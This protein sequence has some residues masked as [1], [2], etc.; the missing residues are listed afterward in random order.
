MLVCLC[1]SSPRASAQNADNPVFPDV[2]PLARDS[3]RSLPGLIAA[4]NWPQAIRTLQQ[5][6][7]E[8]AE[9]V[10][11]SPADDKVFITARQLIH[12]QLRA[13]PALL[14]RYRRTMAPE[15]ERLLQAGQHAAVERAMFMTA[16]GYEA[17]LRVAEEHL[18]A[19][20]FDAAA[21]TLAQL[22]AHPDHAGDQRRSAAALLMRV[23]SFLPGAGLAETARRWS[24]EGVEAPEP[25]QWPAGA[26]IE[27]ASPLT[28]GGEVDVTG[29][30]AT[31]LRTYDFGA[32][33][34]LDPSRS[35]GMDITPP[36]WVFPLVVGDRV[37]L[38]DGYRVIAMDRYALR[39]QWSQELSSVSNVEVQSLRLN[40]PTSLAAAPGVLLA[41]TGIV[42]DNGERWGDGRL[43]AMDI[44]TGEVLWSVAPESLDA[45]LDN[46]IFRGPPAI[47]GDLAVI[48]ARRADPGLRSTSAFLAG[49]DL[50]TGEARWVRSIAS[51]GSVGYSREISAGDWLAHQDGVV[52]LTERIGAIAAVEAATGRTLWVRL[53]TAPTRRRGSMV[54]TWAVQQPVIHGEHLVVLS[55]DREL[56]LWVDRATGRLAGS[57]PAPGLDNMAQCIVPVGDDTLAIVSATSIGFMPA[58]VARAAA[59]QPTNSGTLDGGGLRGRPFAI[60]GLLYAPVNDGLLAIDPAQPASPTALLMEGAGNAIALKSQ[61][62]LTNDRAVRS[63]LVWEVAERVLRERLEQ[64]PTNPDPALTLAELAFRSGRHEAI[65]PALD[66]ALRIIEGG[67]ESVEARTS[68]QRAHEVILGMLELGGAAWLFDGTSAG[69]TDR[70]A[71]EGLALPEALLERLGSV[72]RTQ[73]ER[74]GVAMIEGRLA[75]ARSEGERAVE[76]Y[77]SI[78]LD[79]ELAASV[80]SSRA[81]TINAGREATRR[82]REVVER[83]GAQAYADYEARARRAM[84]TAEARTQPERIAR[85]Y[86]VSSVAAQAWLRAAEAHRESA[87]T[88]DELAALES[89]LTV[90]ELQRTLGQPVEARVAGEV[91][92]RTLALRIETGRLSSARR[93]LETLPAGESLSLTSLGE[94][95]DLAAVRTRVGERLGQQG[96]LARVGSKLGTTPQVIE[97]WRLAPPMLGT[98]ASRS[99]DTLTMVSDRPRLLGL[100][101]TQRDGGELTLERRWERPFD[102]RI[103]VLQQDDQRLIVYLEGERGRFVEAIDAVSGQSTWRIGPLNEVINMPEDA[104]QRGG[105]VQTTLDGWRQP[106]DLVFAIEAQTLVLA[107][108]NGLASGISLDDGSTLWQAE[109]PMDRVVDVSASE[110]EVVIVGDDVLGRRRTGSSLVLLEA[111]SGAIKQQINNLSQP[112]RWAQ[113]SDRGLIITAVDDGLVALRTGT[114]E[115]AWAAREN[116]LTDTFGAWH[117][118]DQLLVL[119]DQSQLALGELATGQFTGPL[120]A[121]TAGRDLT[122]IS[123]WL[124]DDRIVIASEQGLGIYDQGGTLI[125]TDGLVGLS[126]MLTPAAGRGVAL[127]AEQE[128]VRSARGDL[129]YRIRLLDTRTGRLIDTKRLLLP[130]PPALTTLLDGLAVISTPSV[131]VA[132]PVPTE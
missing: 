32:R 53:D 10:M 71:I 77:Q 122:G 48:I 5:V 56:V 55:S 80:W 102:A 33:A 126:P 39:P 6:L 14:D 37:F 105:G 50:A 9:R 41:T 121:R 4:E 83:F 74:V 124:D 13:Q 88:S 96:R 20:R 132:L 43:H 26:A 81:L 123:A 59:A 15:A 104:R 106:D 75:E 52:Y 79:D 93:L 125:A 28:I 129:G 95:I 18:R 57:L 54:M 61:L 25:V 23:G 68:R 65:V 70:L 58:D 11:Q 19:A 127:L 111:R 64:S 29:L 131:T 60:D 117:L 24:P 87:R 130:E 98:V 89:A 34:V 128:P 51:A 49:I 36:S 116:L 7:D 12:E 86:P 8:H 107:A 1:V 112:F 69:A 45:S 30:T 2:S 3:L 78:V 113:L 100:F 27:T 22:E 44:D 40:E 16:A 46:A 114:G 91:V 84:S 97:G 120:S 108:R 73:Q 109:M 47:E 85:R 94:P 35:S 66:I 67:V 101:E 103:F 17:T 118:G 42:S 119:G 31:P 90:V 62:L 72:A 63:Y 82:L 38:N 115:P 92:G 99:D 21:R 110:G 76:A